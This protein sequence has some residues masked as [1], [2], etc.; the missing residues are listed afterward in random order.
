MDEI[1]NET[2]T[3]QKTI[4][5]FNISMGEPALLIENIKTI[6]EFIPEIDICI[7]TNKFQIVNMDPAN[8][9][10]IDFK[11]FSGVF[12]SFN[13]SEKTSL[14]INSNSFYEILKTYKKNDILKIS[15]NEDD[16]NHLCIEFVNS[17]SRINKIPLIENDNP[18]IKVPELT[19]SQSFM[20][21]P[22]V[23]KEIIKEFK[24]FESVIIK[25]DYKQ[26]KFISKD[27]FKTLEIPINDLYINCD[28]NIKSKYSVDYL[29]KLL[30]SRINSF[31]KSESESNLYFGDDYP[32]KLNM[33]I[34]NKYLLSFI[35]APKVDNDY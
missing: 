22:G 30:S 26:I 9:S 7:D 35:L 29:Y 19:N 25:I 20:I 18:P 16:L 13:I 14:C 3:Q 21:D 1:K 32:L 23:L 31:L 12:T 27:D 6:K 33:G 28:G 24:S 8:V 17:F 11:L 5:P 34:E 10:L 4:K 2:I 15:I